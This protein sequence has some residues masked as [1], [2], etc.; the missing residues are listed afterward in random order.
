MRIKSAQDDCQIQRLQSS[1]DCKDQEIE[2]MTCQ[3]SRMHDEAM[4]AKLQTVTCTTNNY[5]APIVNQGGTLSGNIAITPLN[6]QQ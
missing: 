3:M 5:H 6:N 4:A 2:R 1:N